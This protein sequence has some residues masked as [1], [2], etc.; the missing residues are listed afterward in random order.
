M[1]IEQPFRELNKVHLGVIS[2]GQAPHL[3]LG[4]GP[5]TFPLIYDIYISACSYTQM[6]L[7]H[8]EYSRTNTY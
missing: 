3:A 5:M 2:Q 4:V 6:K 8:P 1:Y 7:G